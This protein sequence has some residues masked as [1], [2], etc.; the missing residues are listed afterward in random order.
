MSGHTPGPWDVLGPIFKE[1]LG[2][3]YFVVYAEDVQIV[4]LK[5][6]ANARF[7]VQACNSHDE[8]LGVAIKTEGVLYAALGEW[9]D[10]NNALPFNSLERLIN[11]VRAVI[12]KAEG[13][14]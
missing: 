11:D 7:I 13:R 1:P 3:P 2:E 5:L 14:E 10:D 8:L 9:L 6:E 12:T 4:R